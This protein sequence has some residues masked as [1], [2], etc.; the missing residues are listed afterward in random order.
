VRAERESGSTVEESNGLMKEWK[1]RINDPSII[2]TESCISL[3]NLKSVAEALCLFD[4]VIQM[5]VFVLHD[6]TGNDIARRSA[7]PTKVHL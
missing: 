3:G 5:R 7:H 6:R 4:F 1:Q 2:Y